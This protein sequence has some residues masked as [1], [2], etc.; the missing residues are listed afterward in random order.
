MT[1]NL[2]QD[3]A[4]AQT[5]LFKATYGIDPGAAEGL[6]RDGALISMLQHMYF[7]AME[8]F[9][10]CNLREHGERIQGQ[11]QNLWTLLNIPKEI[12]KMREIVN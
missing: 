5:E 6:F 2:S 11:A 1:E 4:E 12:E 3:L 9:R 10:E 7:N 8:E